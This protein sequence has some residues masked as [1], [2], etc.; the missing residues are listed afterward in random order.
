MQGARLFAQPA[1]DIVLL[2]HAV[3]VARLRLPQHAEQVKDCHLAGV[4]AVLLRA[5]VLNCR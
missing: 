2:G 3:G 5:R 1:V 4:V